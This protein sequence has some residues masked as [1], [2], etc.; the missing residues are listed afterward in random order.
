MGP[1]CVQRKQ[2]DHDAVKQDRTASLSVVYWSTGLMFI[3]LRVGGWVG[4][5]VGREPGLPELDAKQREM[6]LK[7][8][9]LVT[10]IV[11]A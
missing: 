1:G 3:L 5:W 4:G 6:G 8:P 11:C 7:G 9:F 10:S 2:D